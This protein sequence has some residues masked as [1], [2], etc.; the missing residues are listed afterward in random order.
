MVTDLRGVNKAIEPMGGQQSGISLPSLLPKRWPLI[1]ID[2]KDCF[3]TITYKKRIEKKFAF[4]VPIHN[5]YQ[6]ARKL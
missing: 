4:T 6:I 5:N 1:V 3:F 2:L